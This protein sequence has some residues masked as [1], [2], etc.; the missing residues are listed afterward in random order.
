MSYR[1]ASPSSQARTSSVSGWTQK[2][3]VPARLAR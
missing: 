3:L 2:Q 1:P